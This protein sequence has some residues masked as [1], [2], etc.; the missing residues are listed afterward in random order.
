MEQDLRTLLFERGRVKEVMEKIEA[1]GRPD[2]LQEPERALLYAHALSFYGDSEG[3]VKLYSEIPGSEGLEPERLWGLAQAQ[4]QAGNTKEAGLAL[5]EAMRRHPSDWLLPQIYHTQSTLLIYQ[6]KSEQ[7]LKAVEQGIAAARK[8]PTLVEWIVLEGQRGLVRVHQGEPEEAVLILRRSADQLL[9]RESVL[10]ASSML[11]NLAGT[12]ANLGAPSEA[13][14]C[15]DQARKAAEASGSMRRLT[16]LRRMQGEFLER[17]GTL[18]SAGKAYAE[19]QRLAGEFGLS[20]LQSQIERN[21]AHLAFLKG[22]PGEALR[23]IRET[24]TWVRERG[25]RISEPMCLGYEGKFLLHSGAVQEALVSLDHARTLAESIGQWDVW[26]YVALYLSW[27]YCESKDRIKTLHWLKE[28][29]QAA[30]E[31]HFLEALIMDEPQVLTSLLLK[32]GAEIEPTEALSRVVIKLRHPALLKRLLKSSPEGRVHFLRAL[33]ISDARHFRGELEKLH[34]DPSKEVRRTARVLVNGWGK[35]AYRVYGFGTLRVF[36][37]GKMFADSEWHRPVV[38]RLF[39][40]ILTH[41]EKWLSTETILEGLWSQADPEASRKSLTVYFSQLRQVF[42]P[43]ARL[44]GD[45]VILQSQRGAYGFFP[46]ERFWI[47]AREFEKKTKQAEHAHLAR[48]FKEA[49]KD[50]REALDLYLGDYLEEF[51]YE[52]WLNQRRDYLREVYFRSALRYAQLERDSGNLPEARRV[53]E[54][55]LFKDLSRSGCAALLIQILTQMKL[56]HEAKEWGQRHINYMKKELKEKPAPEVVEA[57][58]QLK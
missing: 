7:A 34:R 49:R 56:T 24:L 17:Q 18:E 10:W 46:G 11:V 52:D 6:G 42:E 37:E 13:E 30:E 33:K 23:R 40:F 26:A 5:E 41:P 44:T 31:R 55:A 36:L 12:L 9:A 53:L 48:N 21:L 45:N 1:L 35:A 2:P 22:D 4:V 3:A 32:M 43:W 14:K 28:C 57:L 8:S 51:P 29:L 54:E 19:A 47:D 15:L 20:R 50:Y 27:G 25:L 39:A 38:R 58:K 16:F